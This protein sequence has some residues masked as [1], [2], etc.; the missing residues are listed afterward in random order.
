MTT[1]TQGA[2]TI[3]DL[4]EGKDVVNAPTRLLGWH[5]LTVDYRTGHGNL[6]PLK[7]GDI[8][9]VTPPLVFCANG[10]HASVRAR[11]ALSRALSAIVSCVELSGAILTRD[12]EVCAEVRRILS[13]HDATLVLHERACGDAEVALL[14]ERAAGREPHTASWHVIEVKRRWMRGEAT[15]KE[16]SAAWSAARSTAECAAKSAAWSAWSA[17]RSAAECAAWSAARSAARSAAEF[18]AWSAW[19]AAWSAARSAAES[20]QNERLEAALEAMHD[21]HVAAGTV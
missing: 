10:L 3:S 11:D 5:F 20:A 15:S 7:A 12:D 14:A 2:T 8:L 4:H 6:G 19:C 9:R 1:T 18:A 13:V 21:A 16:L 17:A